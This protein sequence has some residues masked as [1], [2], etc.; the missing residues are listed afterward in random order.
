MAPSTGS[1]SL[2][3]EKRPSSA[4]GR[5]SRDP[6]FDQSDEDGAEEAQGITSQEKSISIYDKSSKL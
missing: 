5:I 1:Q 2:E 3:A 6:E 4:P